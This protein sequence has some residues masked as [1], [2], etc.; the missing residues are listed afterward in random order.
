MLSVKEILVDLELYGVESMRRSLECIIFIT[1]DFMEHIVLAVGFSYMDSYI[2]FYSMAVLSSKDDSFLEDAPYITYLRVLVSGSI[3]KMKLLIVKMKLLILKV[4]LQ[5]IISITVIR[6]NIPNCRISSIKF[7]I[8]G[9]VINLPSPG[10]IHTYSQ[11]TQCS[12]YILLS[13]SIRI[14]RVLI[15]GFLRVVLLF[16]LVLVFIWR[17]YLLI[18]VLAHSSSILPLL[19]LFLLFGLLA[20][21]RGFIVICLHLPVFVFIHDTEFYFLLR[22][23]LC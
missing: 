15:F 7:G 20:I 23:L 22:S 18:L 21:W 10:G 17:F 16:V 5:C 9:S 12:N 3:V 2:V 1:L 11:N 19:P 8:F 14:P 6:G 4:H 13:P